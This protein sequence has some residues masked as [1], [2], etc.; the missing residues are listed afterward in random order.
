M[1][2]A[3]F[4]PSN[5]G[6]HQHSLDVYLTCTPI[7]HANN[8]L[9]RLPRPRFCCI[10]GTSFWMEILAF[11]MREEEGNLFLFQILAVVEEKLVIGLET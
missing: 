6:F 7:D 8:D 3:M 5:S 10:P 11:C 1:I 4:E 9:Q 2:P